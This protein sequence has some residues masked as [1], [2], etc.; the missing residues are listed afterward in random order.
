MIEYYLCSQALIGIPAR[1]QSVV[2][3]ASMLDMPVSF[4]VV[5]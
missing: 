5:I 1:A 2:A 3:C 4:L